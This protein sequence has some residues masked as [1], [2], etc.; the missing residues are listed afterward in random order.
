MPRLAPVMN[1]TLPASR[2][3]GAVPVLFVMAAACAAR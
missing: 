3:T 2:P 1:T